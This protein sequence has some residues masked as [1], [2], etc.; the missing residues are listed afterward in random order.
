MAYFSFIP[1]SS[2]S[3]VVAVGLWRGDELAALV[4][5]ERIILERFTTAEGG[6]DRVMQ[7]TE[8]AYHFMIEKIELNLPFRYTRERV[9]NH[10]STK[11]NADDINP[12]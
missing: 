6:Q 5:I 10:G 8:K 2:S 3:E 11:K 1:T 4:A 7:R 9:T 12:R